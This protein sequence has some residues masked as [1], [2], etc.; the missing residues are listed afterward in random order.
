MLLENKRIVLTGGT[1]GI[2]L[3]FVKQLLPE[4]AIIVIARPSARLD[5]LRATFPDITIYEADLANGGEVSNCT[6]ELL[7]TYDR[8]DVLINN[9]AIQHVPTFL[10]DDFKYDSI[11]TDIAVNLT[12]PCLLSAKLLPLLQKAPQAAIININS[13]LGLVPKTTSAVYCASKGGL[14]I[15]SQSLA[16]QLENT[17]I[18]VIQAF[19][20]LVDT[21][22]TEGRGSGKMSAKDAA[23]QI[24]AGIQQGKTQINIGKVKLLRLIERLSPP[25]A[26]NIMKSA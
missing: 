17:Q 7:K 26:R 21:A 20:P 5:N 6:D 10:D 22:M 18:N 9:A 13:G 4:N 2:G 24:I 1:S 16:N 3:E 25:L 12:A 15:F 23:S 19:L 14:N 11:A 8:V